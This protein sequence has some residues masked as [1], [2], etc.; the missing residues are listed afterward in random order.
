MGERIQHVAGIVFALMFVALLAMI[1]SNVL[2]I[3]N[4]V[5]DRLERTYGTTEMHELLAFDDTR[6]TGSTVISAIKNYDSLYE[7]DMVINVEGDEYGDS[8][9]GYHDYNY[10]RS[11]ISPADSYTA[12]LDTN[13]NGMTTGITF[14]KVP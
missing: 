6:V 1:N 7:Y 10:A 13:A 3:G 12:E 4:S 9:M 8:D 5:N 11:H 2:G 14:T